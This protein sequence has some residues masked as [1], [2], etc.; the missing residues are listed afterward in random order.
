M[1]YVMFDMLCEMFADRMFQTPR[2]VLNSDVIRL[3][4]E[5]FPNGVDALNCIV[6]NAFDE[7]ISVYHPV[8]DEIHTASAQNIAAHCFEYKKMYNVSTFVIVC[9]GKIVPQANIVIHALREQGF[10]VETIGIK[11]LQYN[12]T[13]HEYVP[14][15][16]LCK[17][18]TKDEV[19]RAYNVKG[20]QIPKIN[21]AT[22]AIAKWYGAQPGQMFKILRISELN[23]VV[24]I[25]KQPLYDVT[26]R[27][28]I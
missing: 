3:A 19:L 20:S 7:K 26:Y 10:V 15:H 5:T 28:V 18:E 14:R 25:K 12:P 11:N 23:D 1:Q 2:D 8:S 6:S 13:K 24:D 21:H 16:V 17:K 27:M 9:R 22:D 4:L